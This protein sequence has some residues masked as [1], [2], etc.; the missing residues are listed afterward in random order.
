VERTTRRPHRARPGRRIVREASRFVRAATP[1]ALRSIL[2]R[3]SVSAI[4][5]AFN[6]ERYVGEALESI[7]RQRY[8]PLEVIVVDD[9]STDS[10]AAIASSFP[11]RCLRTEHRGVAAARNRGLAAAGGDLIAFLD[12]D[13]AWTDGSLDRRVTHLLDN[14]AVGFVL[15]RTELL[16]E[17]DRKSRVRATFLR[18]SQPGVLTTFVGRREAIDSVGPFDESYQVAEDVDWFARAR[19][20]GVKGAYLDEICARYRVH[21]ANTTLDRHAEVGESVA[22]AL[23]ASLD[24]RR[25]GPP[26]AP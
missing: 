3:P 5:P 14:P 23:K 24:R 4:V 8:R 11:V 2:I 15:G 9:G 22:R 25:A 16:A 7:L 17:A 19:D 10:T 1:P 26:G 13:D 20:A 6:R 18:E 21:W 12:A